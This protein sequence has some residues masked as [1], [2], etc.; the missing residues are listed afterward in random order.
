VQ[1]LGQAVDALGGSDDFIGH[2]WAGSY[3]ILTTLRRP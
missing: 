1:F 2:D 3:T